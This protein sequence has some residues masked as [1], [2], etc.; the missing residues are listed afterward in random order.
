MNHG[1]TRTIIW[2]LVQ[3]KKMLEIERTYV[4]TCDPQRTITYQHGEYMVSY[5]SI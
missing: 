1:T 3:T 2:N 4:R 5:A